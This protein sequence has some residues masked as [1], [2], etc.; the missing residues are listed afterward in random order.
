L[1][2]SALP[3]DRL[4]LEITESAL[5]ADTDATLRKLRE[6]KA[7]GIKLALD[8]FGTGYSSLTWLRRMPADVVK[9]DK[10]FVGGLPGNRNDTALIRAILNLGAALSLR[11]VAEGVETAE[12][13][14]LLR[15]LGCGVAQGYLFAPPLSGDEIKAAAPGHVVLA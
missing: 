6:L 11:T 2:E 4:V 13:V 14:S 7:L 5:V 8:D 10:A 15:E 12:Q 1:R 9:I 3:A